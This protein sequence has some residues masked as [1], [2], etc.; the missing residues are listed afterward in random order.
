MKRAIA[1]I[2]FFVIAFSFVS[3]SSS[4]DFS[5]DGVNNEE[6]SQALT[7]EDVGLESENSEENLAGP[8]NS[9]PDS[10]TE[11]N[12]SSFMENQE[13]SFSENGDGAILVAYFTY[14]ENAELPYDVDASSSASIQVFNGEIT[15]NTGIMARIIA[16]ATGG[17]LFSIRT[18]TPYPDSYNATVSVGRTEKDEGIRPDLSTHIEDLSRYDI[19][20]VGF[21]NWWYGMPM[22]M[23]SFFEEY[24]FGGKTIIPFCTSG[25]S[26]F[27]DT[28]DEIRDLE[29]DAVVREGLHIGGSS[30]S[31]A[32][33]RIEEWISELGLPE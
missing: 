20:F 10:S 5:P 9:N 21:P 30:V 26:A 31:G 33:S 15:G 22:A 3:C 12:D 28:I 14:G 1:F 23:Y 24:D 2:L 27:S 16:E 11:N 6:V 17:E 13:G 7:G 32:E 4:G 8:D 29:P 18:T 25:G 19:V